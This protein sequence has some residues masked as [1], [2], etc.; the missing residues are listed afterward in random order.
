MLDELEKNYLYRNILLEIR[1]V[2][3]CLS[4][5]NL[6]H[7]RVQDKALEIH[8][9]KKIKENFSLRQILHNMYYFLFLMGFY[10]VLKCTIILN[11]KR[12]VRNVKYKT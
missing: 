9:L 5:K 11:E 12:F 8:N 4:S 10:Y 2:E 6:Q 7:P 1:N 3:P